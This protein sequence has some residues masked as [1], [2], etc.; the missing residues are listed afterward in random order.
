[1]TNPT[2]DLAR[3]IA[4]SG[5]KDG[6]PPAYKVREMAKAYLEALEENEKLLA[7]GLVLAEP[8]TRTN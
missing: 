5:D 2:I 6:M 1:M 3:R 7:L 8:T 4:A